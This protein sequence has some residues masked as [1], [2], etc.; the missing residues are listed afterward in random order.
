MFYTGQT[1]NKR[2]KICEL[3]GEGGTSLVY[4]AED[5]KT[6]TPVAVKFMKEKV[7]TRFIEDIIRFKREIEIVKKLDHPNIIKVYEVGEYENKPFIITELLEGESLD[8]F[9][10]NKGSLPLELSLEIVRQLATAL[11]YIHSMGIVHRD[12]KPG[13]IFITE[14]KGEISL[15]LFDFGI[16]Y[17][18]EL[19]EIDVG[20]EIAGT[21]GFMSPEATG[22]LNKRV[23]E[24][25]DL[26][27]L[28]VIMYT[29]LC[30]AQP[31]KGEEI[32]KL[33]HQQVALIPQELNRVNKKIPATINKIT[34]KLLLKDPDARYQS[35]EGL[36]HDIEKYLKGEINFT[37]GYKDL[38]VRLKYN[39]K[40]IGREEELRKIKA[41]FAKARKGFGNM[42]LI[43]GE[44]GIGKSSLLEE[45]SKYLYGEDAF[46]ICSRCL[47]QQS[48]A[49]Y[50]PFKD[51]ID[52]Y[53]R[54]IEKNSPQRLQ[55]EL[56]SLNQAAGNFKEILIGLNPHLEKYIGRAEK[57]MPLEP[58]RENQRLLM[59]LS[60]FFIKLRQKDCTMV[61]LLE[62]LH[63]ADNGS[64]NLL[65]EILK[66]IEPVKLLV[67]GTY[68][69][70]EIEKDHG[71]ESIRLEAKTRE[72]PFKEIKL[73]PLDPYMLN[74]LISA[75]LGENIENL[76]GLT[77]FIYKKTRGNP[78]FAINLLRELIE[79]GAVIWIDGLWRIDWPVIKTLAV[80]SS[81][82]ETILKRTEGLS[83]QQNSLLIKAAVIGRELDI[84][85]LDKIS[86]LSMDRMVEHIDG[87]IAMEFLEKGKDRGKLIFVHD[88]I[89]D[90]FYQKLDSEE[91][92]K[93]HLSVAKA[94]EEKHQPDTER[95]LFELVHHYTEAGNEDKILEYIIP[96]AGKAKSAY[97]NEE[98]ISYYSTAIGLFE[99]R[100]LK[101]SAGWL[102]C[103]ESLVD[104]YLTIGKNDEAVGLAGALLPMIPSAINRARI[105]RKLGIAYFKKGDWKRCEINLSKGLTLL[106]ERLPKSKPEWL[107][108]IIKELGIHVSGSI[109]FKPSKSRISPNAREEDRE[110]ILC[111]LTLNWMYILSDLSKLVCNILR[112]LNLS[113]A[114]LKKS[115]ELGIS[116][117]GYA[118]ACMTM[119]FF[120]R[121]LKFHTRALHLRE[122]IGDKWGVAQ[123]HQFL[124]F[125]YS[126]AGMHKESI[127]NFEASKAGFAKTGDMW[128]LGMAVI[129]LG[130]AFRYTSQ[131]KKGI[132]YQKKYLDISSMIKNTYGVIS[133]HI[134]LAYCHMECGDFDEAGRHLDHAMESSKEDK[135]IYLYCCSLIC[136][137][138]L[139]L[140]KGNYNNA[141]MLLEEAR[142]INEENSFLKDYTV[143][144]YPYLCECHIRKYMEQ[145]RNDMASKGQLSNIYP[146]CRTALKKT[147]R[148]VNHYSAALRCMAEY[149]SLAGKTSK[150]GKYFL[151]SIELSK[152]IDR[153][154]ELGKS[155][156]GLGLLL[157]S[158]G[159]QDEAKSNF[160]HAYD[161][162]RD[163]GSAEYLKKCSKFIDGFNTDDS[164][165]N[166]PLMRLKAERRMST[167]LT[168]GRYLSS[169]LDLDE[170]LEKI[171][172][173]V[174]EHVGAEIGLL[175]LYNEDSDNELELCVARNISKEEYRSDGFL[176]S[177]S[178]ISKVVSD[179]IP[180]IVSDASLDETLKNKSSVIINKIRSVMCAPVMSKNELLGI[181]YLENTLIG[182]L[183]S[184]DDLTILDMIA[185][186][187]GVSVENA[188]L[189][190]KMM[191]YSKDL[192]E[193]RD[194]IVKLNQTL[195]E[196]VILRT[197]ELEALN[198]EYKE[199][200]EELNEKNFE[201][202]AMIE[203]LQEH[204]KTV[205]EL[206]VT[207]E[208]NRF[209]MDVHDTL[210]HS[211]VLLIKL[212]EVCKLDLGTDMDKSEKRLSD[213]INTARNGMK[214]LKRSIY[215]LVPE[216]LEANKLITALKQL[217]DDFGSSGSKINF[218]VYGTN[219]YQ[220]PAYSYTLFKV[221]QE[222]MTNALRHGK[223]KNIEIDLKFNESRITLAISDDGCGCKDIKKG[224]GLNGMEQ[225]IRELNGSISFQAG[226]SSGFRVELELPL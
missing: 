112:M 12:L 59:V 91:K 22:L 186:Q 106:G 113:E 47:D 38:R 208:R 207:K 225:R 97:A 43:G 215:G 223:A 68:R 46:F 36:L 40:P 153:K 85:L 179:K 50:Q 116:T 95:V 126:W 69:D 110:I 114:R 175:F 77:D 226:D 149:Y 173:S 131:Y 3:L 154:Y 72:L 224:F 35:A 105:H 92:R 87:F 168:T 197:R 138:Y 42:V 103:C 146:L 150:A 145:R 71:L 89:R 198:T 29:L 15:K 65:L 39:T 218:N 93:I 176:A 174:L 206:A 48:K 51:L 7:T 128:E 127:F 191:L 45:V 70:N 4:K 10:M 130:Y 18:L 141:I 129:G 90:V 99:K 118:S 125:T 201:L 156:Y 75:L 124:G 181:I 202:N 172:D 196:R 74:N 83:S 209:A 55:Q 160:H 24:R 80:S 182:S 2:Y 164:N 1:I 81:V 96:A 210:G 13:N 177:K 115:R 16:A 17:I 27:S 140:E 170:L 135:I 161:I 139:E 157:R 58:E 76:H 204:A 214:E 171:M 60:D 31:F 144:L 143:N 54:Q 73:A 28:G 86:G 102:H 57:I 212:L 165:E 37:P 220:N 52:D 14:K 53:M 205:E 152:S 133:G 56:E 32:N 184:D 185:N 162:F 221:C 64:L 11:S 19:G 9:I 20:E 188:R 82:L 98:A 187:A 26:Y 94:L 222:S 21:F 134:E 216:K 169:I 219:E 67:I 63:W 41:G 121:A 8:V 213:A 88:R 117:S 136:K 183:F 33:L 109:L 195:E 137:G 5:H 79:K 122:E 123:S 62:D 203:Q 78:F 142:K 30:G 193:S 104:V 194:E 155:Y 111:Y 147:K 6:G 23:D 200:A 148:W 151:S 34:M 189:Y 132:E 61:F 108:S 158:T 49:P 119:P 199:L 211:M 66:K 100:N 84:A 217:V 120:K 25:S 101:G 178:I 192:E 180:L 163:I 190:K 166:N 44:A 159:L 107:L 167:I